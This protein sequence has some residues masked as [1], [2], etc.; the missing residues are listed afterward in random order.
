MSFSISSLLPAVHRTLLPIRAV[1]DSQSCHNRQFLRSFPEGRRGIRV[2][3]RWYC[4]VD[5]FVHAA[6]AT[7][8]ALLNRQ[9]VEIPRI[10]RLSLGLAMLSK[11][12]LTAEQLR[13][14][15]EQSHWR[16]ETLDAALLRLGMANEKQI[17]AARS[18]QWGY[19]VLVQEHIGHMVQSD[20]PQSIL[21]SCSAV[22]LH[23]S[24]AAKR[25]LLG[26]VYRIEHSLLKSVEQ[27]TDCRV[28]PCF[29]TATDF[30]EQNERL[31]KIVNY[32]EIFIED[33]G[34]P[35][36]MA[37]ALGRAAVEIHA[38][39]VEFTQCKGHIW[40][41]LTGKDGIADVVFRAQAAAPDALSS[42]SDLPV[43]TTGSLG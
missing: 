10:P 18:A 28:E 16:G 32:R 8:F 13:T 22:P 20:I 15:S 21:Q 27:M 3:E 7:L 19:P 14:A 6:R 42:R 26:F 11:G 1:C 36:A 39:A 31:T 29:I 17:T 9:V 33:S 43:E 24:Q 40:T 30:A 38:G 23:Y 41:R 25:I 37:R 5:C 4:S 35:E 12:Y 2:G 34:S